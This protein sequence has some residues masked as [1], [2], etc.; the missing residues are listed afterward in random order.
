MCPQGLQAQV[1]LHTRPGS[2]FS[3]AGSMARRA[4]RSEASVGGAALARQG[5]RALNGSQSPRPFE[6]ATAILAMHVPKAEG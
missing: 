4:S 5:P 3:R 2:E 6:I 1:C